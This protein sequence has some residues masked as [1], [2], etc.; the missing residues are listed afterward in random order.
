MLRTHLVMSI[1]FGLLFAS[2]VS[3]PAIF[4]MVLIVATY[5]PDIDTAFSSIGAH[6]IFKF[7]QWFVHH[8]GI[9]HSLTIG[10]ALSIALAFL[11]PVAALP[12]FL[13]YSLHIYLDAFTPE[14]VAPFWPWRKRTS[15]KVITGGKMD[16]SFFVFL[17]IA[18]V[19]VFAF[20]IF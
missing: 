7:L 15:W 3:Q 9:L 6:K 17:L 1:L 12:F 20:M 13:G 5:V 10:I 2:F 8:R 18:D 11:W 14:G 19:I 4:F 16:T